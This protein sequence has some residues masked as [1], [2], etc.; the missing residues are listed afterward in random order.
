MR[1]DR[2]S[3]PQSGFILVE[4]LVALILGIAIVTVLTSSLSALRRLASRP[5]ENANQF[6][7]AYDTMASWAHAARPSGI[8]RRG[9]EEPAFYGDET[10]L[11]FITIDFG[12]SQLGGLTET[13][14]SVRPVANNKFKSIVVKTRPV[15]TPMIV[16]VASDV[17]ISD[18]YDA[19]FS[20]LV[21]NNSEERPSWR[22]RWTSQDKLPLM[23]SL[24]L[25]LS[26]GRQVKFSFAMG[27][28]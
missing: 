27:R 24:E 6:A 3:Q 25:T 28:P 20:Y 2:E 19:Q 26:Q 11:R 23:F 22:P 7:A 5:I 13:E 16:S 14:I 8:V 10:T 1:K 18:I 21:A 12:I 9:H 15:T 4:V 17:L